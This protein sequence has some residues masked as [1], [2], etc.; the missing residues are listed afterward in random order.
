MDNNEQD[1]AL[2]EW[3]FSDCVPALFS[4]FIVDAVLQEDQVRIIENLRGHFEINAV[5]LPFIRNLLL[6]VPLEPH[7]S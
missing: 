4:C 7:S 2:V 5:V 3:N 1:R 6:F